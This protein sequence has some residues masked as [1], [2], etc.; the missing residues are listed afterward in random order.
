MRRL[1]GKKEADEWKCPQC[2]RINK[3]SSKLCTKCG[4]F[5][6]DKPI[7][8]SVSETTPI[9]VEKPSQSATT[10]EG[11]KEL[12]RGKLTGL[13]HHP[14]IVL[15]TKRLLIDDRSIDLTDILEVYSAVKSDFMMTNAK[16]F[17]R[18]KDGDEIEVKMVPEN[19]PSLGSAL[20]GDAESAMRDA[21][22]ATHDRWV[23][24][25]NRLLK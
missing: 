11:E 2:L 18:L 4:Y 15:T 20:F 9:P 6:G 17:V 12:L 7:P 16:M 14:P 1:F 22:K 25:I 21:Q 8:P 10:E 3:A 5:K 13:G 23:N 19:P 24:L